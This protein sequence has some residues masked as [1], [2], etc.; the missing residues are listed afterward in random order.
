MLI[1]ESFARRNVELRDTWVFF[2]RAQHLKNL[3]V[4]TAHE[5]IHCLEHHP[6]SP[7]GFTLL[8]YLECQENYG[9][10]TK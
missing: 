2:F 10:D 7:G 6:L 5:S 9:S 4:P 8:L 3:L 1:H